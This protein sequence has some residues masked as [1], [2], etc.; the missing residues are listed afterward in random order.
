MKN[1]TRQIEIMAPVG[2]YESLDAA[3]Q[4]GADA[5]Y[6]GIGNLNMR[7][8]STANFNLNDLKK[9]TAICQ[10]NNIKTYL[11]VN[12]VVYN[13]ELLGMKKIILAAKKYKVTA[14]IAH[15][16]A[17]IQF[18]RQQ[19]MR[20]HMSTQANI[21]NIE[22]VRYYSQFADVMV[23]ARELSLEQ[24]KKIVSQIKKEKI[25]G[26]NGELI[27]IEIFIHGALCM[28]ISGKCYLSLHHYNESANRGRCLQICRRAY[29]VKDLETGNKLKIDNKYIISPQDLCTLDFIDQII[30]SGATVLKI[31]GRARPPEY[32]K[33]VTECYRQAIDAYFANKLTL[34]LKKKLKKRLASVFNRGFWDGYYLGKKLGQWSDV[35]GSKA[36]AQKLYVG[37]GRK[38]FD[39]IKVGEFLIEDNVLMTG[40][41]VIITGPVSGFYETKIKEIRLDNK[42]VEKTN[43]GDIVSI[44]L[45]H[46]IR[47]SDRLYKIVDKK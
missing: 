27:K 28:A 17:V 45:D 19:K 23:M 14:I 15:D 41:K 42:V 43:Q 30:D 9:I 36:T 20:I 3:I 44:P 38:Y 46:K 7:S 4:A 34:A 40:D 35:Y 22:A 26:P 39:K 1:S 13:N 32:V 33:T 24:V 16:Q 37:K 21:S 47:K 11:T 2:S 6:F 29:E 5:V 8:L 31:E 18:A 25:T 12:T 10:K